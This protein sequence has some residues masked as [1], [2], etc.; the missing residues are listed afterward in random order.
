[1]KSKQNILVTGAAGFLGANLVRK[2]ITTEYNVHIILRKTSNIW[3]IQDIIHKLDIHTAD[4]TQENQIKE[5][6]K[7]VNPL[8]IIHLATQSVFGGNGYTEDENEVIN[9]NFIGTINLLKAAD[10]NRYPI[11]I[12]TGSSSEYG[13]KDKPMKEKDVCQP[14]SMYAVAKCAGTLYGQFVAMSKKLPIVTLRLFSPFGPF[15][16]E[17]RFM[18]YAITNALKNKEIVVTNP[19]AVRDYI[20]VDD[21]VE[22]YLKVLKLGKN[23]KGEIFNIGSGKQISIKDVLKKIIKYT[24]SKSLV[25]TE[26]KN[27]HI[28]EPSCWQADINKANRLL[29]WK[30]ENT[31][32]EGLKRT[33]DWFRDNL[34]RYHSMRGW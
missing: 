28:S 26:S 3:R 8:S 31:F 25:I 4:I 14:M 24:N 15:D 10:Y 33:I 5:I 32:D 2:L 11:F 19:Q 16:D 20:F 18:S 9:T 17:R 23:L 22:A 6:V 30:P 7:V 21:I 34:K 27:K 1:M 29:N 12:N 13:I